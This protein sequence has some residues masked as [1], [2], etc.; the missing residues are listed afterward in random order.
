MVARVYSSGRTQN[1][2]DHVDTDLGIASAHVSENS[3]PVLEGQT[4]A[5]QLAPPTEVEPSHTMVSQGVVSEAARSQPSEQGRDAGEQAVLGR[6]GTVESPDGSFTTLES[7]LL[8]QI[9][10]EG[11]PS[12]SDT[13]GQAAGSSTPTGR[14]GSPSVVRRGFDGGDRGLGGPLVSRALGTD[15]LEEESSVT[16]SAPVG[17]RVVFRAPAMSDTEESSVKP[18]YPRPAGETH[19]K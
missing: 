2:D 7:T 10:A 16:L 11:S 6:T 19:A 5:T 18:R 9:E 15:D 12:R 14:G 3:S 17:P 13:N 8:A 4:N 1:Q